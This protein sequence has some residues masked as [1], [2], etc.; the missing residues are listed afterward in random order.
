MVTRKKEKKTPGT[1]DKNISNHRPG[2]NKK[3]IIGQKKKANPI[4]PL[5]KN[6]DICS[7]LVKRKLKPSINTAML[8]LQGWSTRVEPIIKLT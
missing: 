3:N 4:T 2:E 6:Q 1:R 7:Q 8:Q 5:E